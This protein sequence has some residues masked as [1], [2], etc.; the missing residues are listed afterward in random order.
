MAS[1]GRLNQ[2]NQ[3]ITKSL[4]RCK[5]PRHHHHCRMDTDSPENRQILLQSLQIDLRVAEFRAEEY[6]RLLLSVIGQGAADA[7]TQIRADPHNF[8]VSRRLGAESQAQPSSSTAGDPGRRSPLVTA[9]V[10]ASSSPTQ[11]P[12]RLSA[13]PSVLT[14]ARPERSERSIRTS[15]RAAQARV[16]A[17]PRPMYA[18]TSHYSLTLTPTD[19]W[20]QNMETDF[21][22]STQ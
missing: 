1:T 21:V 3:L 6:R 19:F 22:P 10:P 20:V 18:R 5:F 12:L 16:L 7:T 4:Q 14:P 15:R 17:S 2:V 8:Q 9:A 11:P 13:R